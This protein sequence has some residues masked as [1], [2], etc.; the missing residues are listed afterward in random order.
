MMLHYLNQVAGVHDVD[1][2]NLFLRLL[3][4][5]FAT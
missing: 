4:V 2:I 1:K 3:D 5:V